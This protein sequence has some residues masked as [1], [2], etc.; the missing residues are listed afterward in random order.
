MKNHEFSLTRIIWIVLR[1]YWELL[2]V[3]IFSFR[4]FL[5][6]DITRLGASYAPMSPYVMPT[7]HTSPTAPGASSCNIIIIAYIQNILTGAGFQI[8]VF[9]YCFSKFSK[10]F[11]LYTSIYIVFDRIRPRFQKFTTIYMHIYASLPL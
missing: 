11:V 10:I 7:S 2:L 1:C 3:Q 6:Q 8:T 9:I 5:R 4:F